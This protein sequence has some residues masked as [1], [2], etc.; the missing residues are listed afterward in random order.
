MSN[1]DLDWLAAHQPQRA[2]LDPGARER[3]LRALVQHAESRPARRGLR[4]RS[5]FR[6][7]AFGFAVAA[8]AAAVVAGLLL[9]PGKSGDG[10]RLGD[11]AHAS[12]VAVQNH[13]TST[14]P[15]L[16]LASFVSYSG[17]PAGDA[18]VVA[19]TTTGGGE[20][21]TVYDL[22]SDSGEYYFSR[23]R[24]GLAG[25]VSAHHDLA[26]GLFAREV[27]AA[28]LAATGSVE[29]AAQQMAD[30]A[31]PSKVIPRTEPANTAAIAAAKEAAG[32]EPQGGSRYDNWVWEDSLDALIAGSG[33]PQVRAGVL[34]IL[35][36]LPDVTVTHG[37]SGGEPALVLT[38][39]VSELGQGYTEQL[40]INAD[41]GVPIRLVG[42]KAAVSYAV[43]RVSLAGLASSAGTTD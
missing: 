35:A 43:T 38:A 8:G 7:R 21:V 12:H 20:S 39:G 31:D 29:T 17:T 37:T 6:T 25:E 24:S 30:A 34:Q 11:R 10:R 22:Y 2:D 23:T 16:R 33:Q 32:G 1:H 18:T 14:S 9:S 5:L 42:G 28:K 3:A 19:R 41:T 27:A 40:T 15:L 36:T 13:A 4:L 26:G